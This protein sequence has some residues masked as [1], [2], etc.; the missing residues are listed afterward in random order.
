MLD[1]FHSGALLYS[2]NQLNKDPMKPREFKD[3]IF[4][5]LARVGA[6]FSSPKRV[7][8]IELLA[9]GERTVE[10]VATATG[11]SVANTSR[12]LS[13]L[14]NSGL[15]NSRREGLY[16][17]Y[18]ISE[19]SV[20]TAFQALRSLA[21]SRLVEVHQLA[22]AFFKEVDGA[23]PIGIE[24]LLAR[25]AAGDAVVID[26]RPRLEYRAGHLPGAVSIPLD[27]L[28]ARLTEIDGDHRVVAYCRGPYC[29]MSAEAVTQLRLAGIVAQRLVVGPLEWRQ[30]GLPIV[31]GSGG[32]EVVLAASTT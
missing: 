21:E 22:E 3:S 16:A 2:N 9:Q 19:V 28:P 1:N 30:A 25:A 11:M 27:E 5:Q 24:E 31:S 4:E 29:V 6:A 23:E 18:R 20:V 32:D 15:V 26:V 8:I 12:H 17:F 13:V 10:S 14:R 7:E